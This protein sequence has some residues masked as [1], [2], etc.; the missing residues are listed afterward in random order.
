[1][2]ADGRKETSAMDRKWLWFNRRPRS[3]T[4]LLETHAPC[5]VL[6]PQL[7]PAA[8]RA[9]LFINSA[10]ISTSFPGSLFSASI[11]VEKRPWLS[12]VTCLPES[13][14][15]TKCVLGEGWQCRPCRHCEEGNQ[16]AIDF[17]ARWPS[18][19]CLTAGFM[20]YTHG[21]RRERQKVVVKP[22][23]RHRK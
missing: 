7:E 14:R 16:Q 12:L 3:W 11:V 19:K 4:A 15:F 6:W 22:I 2:F 8:S 10:V 21:I 9:F 18:T 1:M 20:N 5:V 23:G 13:G 17:V